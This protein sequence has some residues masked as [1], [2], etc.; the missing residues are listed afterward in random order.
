MKKTLILGLMTLLLSGTVQAQW[1]V[2][3]P[4][5]TYQ[6]VLSVQQLKNTV[7]SLREQ[8]K[9]LDESLDYMR[10]VNATVSNSMTV[11]YLIERQLKLSTECGKLLGR[12]GK[13]GMKSSTLS[14]LTSCVGQIVSNNGRL[15]SLVKSVL[16]TSLRMNDA[17]RLALLRDIE[18]QTEQDERNIWKINRLVGEYETLKRA[19]Q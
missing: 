18:K 2:S 17:E 10:K 8:K 5:N 14:S 16:S 7:S 11:K 12:A 6:G 9:I 19:L 1:I 4:E 13:L 15:I 3:D